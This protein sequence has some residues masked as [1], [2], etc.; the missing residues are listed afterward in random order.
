[1]NRRT[2][3]LVLG[4]AAF[5]PIAASAQDVNLE[6]N[7][8]PLVGAP[9]PGAPGGL[10]QAPNTF[11]TTLNVTWFAA[12]KFTVRLSSGAPVLTYSGNHYYNSPGSVGPT[13]YFAQLDLDPGALVDM[14]V[15]V[16]ND[17]S[18]T[19]NVY[20]A[21]QKYSTN[22][23]TG[24]ST[25][26]TLVSGSSSGTPGFEYQNLS[27]VPAETITTLNGFTLYSYYLAADIASDTEFAGVWVRWR[28]QTSPA[29]AVATFADVPTSSPQ[30][31]FVEALV[32][33]GI[34]AGCGGGNYCPNDPITRGQM[35]VF[36]SAALGLQFPE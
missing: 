14:I 23:S 6:M 30:F 34:T 32:A 18:A 36:L 4:F 19:N 16:Y 3:Y 24:A 20:F 10:A 31:K 12:S 11:G 15:P 7:N 5:V 29:P 2:L 25:A 33:A 22:V 17:P 21:L 27:V 26:A 8:K 13:R 28:R 1:M 35:A 9:A